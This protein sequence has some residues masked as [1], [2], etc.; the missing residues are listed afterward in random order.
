M[1]PLA[2]AGVTAVVVTHDRPALLDRCLQA[3]AAQAR[4]PDAVVVV[5]NGSAPGTARLLASRWPDVDVVRSQRNTGAAGGFHLGVR[6]GVATG[7]AWLWLFNDDDRAVPH[8]LERLLATARADPAVGAAAGWFRLPGGE[9]VRHGARW[10]GRERP[11]HQLPGAE[12]DVDLLCFSGTL[13]RSAAVTEAGLPRAGYFMMFEE[14][15]Y[16]LRLRD[17]GWTLRVV[18]SPLVE[19]SHAGSSGG[20]SP[21]WRGYYQTRNQLAFAL[22]RRSPRTVAWWLVRQAAF[23]SALLRGGDR[24]AERLRLR[25]L[26]AWHAVRGVEGMTVHPSGRDGGAL[27][28]RPDGP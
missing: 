12:T 16:C 9:V 24:R 3:L 6:R 25:T 13:L 23:A 8:A 7:A 17:R 18:G 22:S 21:P 27:T 5:D 10:A 28:R 19:V 11:V 15:E 1:T 14:Y 26:G 4:P 2:G 20:Q